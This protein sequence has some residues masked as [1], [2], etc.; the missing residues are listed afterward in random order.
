MRQV[1]CDEL[2]ICREPAGRGGNR[3]WSRR[4]PGCSPA[5]IWGMRGCAPS[6]FGRKEGGNLWH[7]FSVYMPLSPVLLFVL[8]LMSGGR[9]CFLCRSAVRLAG[10]YISF[11]HRCKASCFNIFWVRWRFLP[12]LRLWPGHIR[13]RR[14]VT[15][16]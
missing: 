5:F 16:W 9:R 1:P 11:A 2:L 8:S 10:R 14:L 13:R 7:T 4:C 3:H 6:C 15:C 12:M